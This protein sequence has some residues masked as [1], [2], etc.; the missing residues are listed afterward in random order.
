MYVKQFDQILFDMADDN[1]GLE[2]S[3]KTGYVPIQDVR[4]A[5]SV[6]QAWEENW[7]NVD[8]LLHTF[9]FKENLLNDNLNG[10]MKK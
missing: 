1:T 9:M 2:C 3:L 5:F 6:S 4:M 7:W 10:K 8:G